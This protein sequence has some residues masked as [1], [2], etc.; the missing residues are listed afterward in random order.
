VRGGHLLVEWAPL[1]VREACSVWDPPGAAIPLMQGIKAR[2][3]PRG[4]LNPGRFVGGS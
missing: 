1:A 3:D 2:L 4:V